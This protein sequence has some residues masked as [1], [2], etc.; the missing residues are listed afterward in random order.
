VP[1]KITIDP[2]QQMASALSVGLSVETEVDVGKR[3]DA[4][5]RVAGVDER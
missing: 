1:V 5:M 2:G 3:H 4:D